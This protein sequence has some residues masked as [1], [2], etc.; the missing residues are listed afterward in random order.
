MGYLCVG[1]RDPHR[2]GSVEVGGERTGSIYGSASSQINHPDWG[3]LQVR[4]QVLW[5]MSH[6]ES[7]I[8][9]AP[10]TDPSKPL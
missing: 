8:N 3:H 2:T 9:D 1:S 4:E 7:L 10:K 6:V 5:G